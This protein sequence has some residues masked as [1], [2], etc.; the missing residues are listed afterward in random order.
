MGQRVIVSKCVCTELTVEKV[1]RLTR[2]SALPW[3][4]VKGSCTRLSVNRLCGNFGEAALQMRQAIV[5]NL[6]QRFFSRECKMAMGRENILEKKGG[7]GRAL[8][9]GSISN[10]GL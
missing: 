9:S 3:T 7:G 6:A 10:I 2:P 8:Q 5:Q 1:L 4:S